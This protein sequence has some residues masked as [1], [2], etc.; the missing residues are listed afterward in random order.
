MSNFPKIPSF[1]IPP[2]VLKIALKT[3]NENF[4]NIFKNC[5]NFIFCS[6]FVRL[7]WKKLDRQQ[8]KLKKPRCRRRILTQSGTGETTI[9]DAHKSPRNGAKRRS[10]TLTGIISPPSSKSQRTEQKNVKKSAL[11]NRTRSSHQ[12]RGLY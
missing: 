12:A 8:D 1:L 10:D 7:I 6:T 4:K 11:W 5:S 9:R 2:W 3:Q